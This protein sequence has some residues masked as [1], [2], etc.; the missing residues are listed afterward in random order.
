VKKLYFISW[1]LLF[2]SLIS[3]EKV[4]TKDVGYQIIAEIAGADDGVAKLVKLDLFTNEPATVDSV[5]IRNGKFSFKGRVNSAYL[6]TIIL[7]N[8]KGKIHLFLDN[9]DIVIKG[10]IK[11]FEKLK[12]IG[13]REDSLFRSYTLDDIFDRK[14]GKEIMLNYP[15]YN[16]TAMVAYYQFQYF[17]IPI[18]SMQLIMSGFNPKVK[19]SYYYD[20]LN[21]LYESIKNVA[22]GQPAPNFK[23]QDS[24]GE[25]VQLDDFKGK[26]VLIDFWASWCAPCRA[27]N[28]ELVKVYETF[29][30]RN[31]TIL[32]VSVDK[33][34]KR[35]LDAID[36]DR[37]P[38]INVS[39]LK[40]WDEVS[41]LYGVKA[42]RK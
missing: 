2:I 24:N 4:E 32:G 21:K 11:H 29:Q 16:Y 36:K 5:R 20:H 3:C 41:N 28:P 9:S 35:W 37:L 13:S 26:F 23:I 39:N 34:K 25:W 14:R 19:E 42:L 40:G 1:I 18:D 17:N 6:H 31:F 27:S 38:W 30:N 8:S 15:K 33:D 10:D 12:V 7:P 22:I